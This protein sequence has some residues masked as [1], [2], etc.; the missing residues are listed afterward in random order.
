MHEKE[1]WILTNK[2][3]NNLKHENE[4]E[5]ADIHIPGNNL[6]HTLQLFYTFWLVNC[7]KTNA[8]ITQSAHN[9]VFV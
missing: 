3:G 4:A 9:S 1:L 5:E 6:H 8:T 7:I 2:R